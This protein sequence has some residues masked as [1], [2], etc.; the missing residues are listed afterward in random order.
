MISG[1]LICRM[2]VRTGGKCVVGAACRSILHISTG[3]SRSCTG[4][5]SRMRHASWSTEPN[6]GSEA[7]WRFVTV[8]TSHHSANVFLAKLAVS[9]RSG[10]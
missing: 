9:Q 3:L 1:V 4:A 10:A 6:G 8:F 2:R 5:D 7:L